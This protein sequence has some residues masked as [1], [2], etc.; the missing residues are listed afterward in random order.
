MA[1]RLVSAVFLTVNGHVGVSL[2]HKLSL[3]SWVRYVT[4][5]VVEGGGYGAQALV[6]EQGV[7]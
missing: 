6:K 7:G 1:T 4:I 3:V 2:D 5:V